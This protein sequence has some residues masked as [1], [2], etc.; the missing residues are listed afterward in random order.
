MQQA[1]WDRRAAVLLMGES[2]PL[3]WL[4]RA[5]EQEGYATCLQP[6]EPACGWQEALYRARERY[7]ALREEYERV[8]A[9][10]QSAGA[11][12]ALLLAQR[13]PLEGVV[14]LSAP[15]RL[16]ARALVG[17][18]Q[19]EGPF[20]RQAGWRQRRDL[21]RL[22]RLARENLYCVE[23]RM[24]AVQSR[25]D[26][27]LPPA[28]ARTLLRESPSAQKQLLRL[29]ESGHIVSRGPERALL[30]SAILAFLRADS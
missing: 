2:E 9:L 16:R 14:C 11:A 30:L 23:C 20:P 22:F 7:C 12:L 10:G 19:G 21:L 17:A 18:P 13:Y 24:L 6:V 29:Y 3:R 5:L 8:Y 27:Y 25:D 15:V 1:T 26:P 28:A 4:E